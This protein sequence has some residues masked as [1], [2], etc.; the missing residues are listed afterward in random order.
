MRDGNGAGVY[1][2]GQRLAEEVDERHEDEP[3]E[4][5]SGKDYAGHFGTDNVADAQ[6]LGSCVGFDGGAFE[7]VIGA[8]V[9]LILG[10]AGPGFEE[11]LVLE[12]GVEAAEAEAEKDA[13]G[14][15]AALFTGDEHVGAGCAFR[16]G[17][18]AVLLHDELAAQGDHE[19]HAQPA[20]DEGQEKDAGV[21]KIEA[22]EDQCREGEDDAG[23]DG[24]A[25]VAGGLDNIVF[26]NGR[27]AKG[28][29][30]T[31]GEDRDGDGGGYGEAGAEAHVDGDGAKDEAEEAAEEDGAEGELGT[32]FFGRDKGPELGCP[33]I[34]SGVAG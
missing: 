9:G 20:A 18:G 16:V 15:G 31:D 22:E 24:L 34:G 12:E 2:A 8:E 19:E 27:A 6:V 28:A 3:G 1:G 10:S 32:V 23:G 13:A 11:V 29:Q 7:D 4:Y 21:L 17:E 26:E 14:E 5:A 30:D 33:K 25:S